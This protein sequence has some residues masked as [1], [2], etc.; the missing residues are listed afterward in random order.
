MFTFDPRTRILF[1]YRKRRVLASAG[2]VAPAPPSITVTLDALDVFDDFTRANNEDVNGP[3]QPST[4]TFWVEE[5]NPLRADI[6]GNKL[7]LASNS[8]SVFVHR[9]NAEAQA[10]PIFI[11]GVVQWSHANTPAII[12]FFNTDAFA[13]RDGMQWRMDDAGSLLRID[14]LTNGSNSG[15]GSVAF[16]PTVNNDYGFE[17]YD[18][19]SLQ[20]A[21][22]WNESA[23]ASEVT[24]QTTDSTHDG[25]SKRLSLQCGSTPTNTVSF[26]YVWSA[27]RRTVTVVGLNVGDG[28]HIVDSLGTTISVATESGGNSAV[29]MDISRLAKG[30]AEDDLYPTSGLSLVVL[31]TGGSLVTTLI[32]DDHPSGNIWPGVYTVVQP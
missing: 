25:L 14:K 24:V 12:N 2:V 23:P 29:T 13:S 16:S 28:C 32:G 22:I 1:Q 8:G 26:D 5:N 4:G 30:L 10:G 9:P 27:F 17:Y 31:E 3:V 6:T 15:I 20:I 18:E 19:D 11:Q 7:V 21:G